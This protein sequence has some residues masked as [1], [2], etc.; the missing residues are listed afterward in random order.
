M[1]YIRKGEIDLQSLINHVEKE[2]IE[3][4]RLFNES[5]LPEKVDNEF[6][7]KLLVSIRKNSY[8]L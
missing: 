5:N 7:N 8:N 4:D 1:I 2:I 6:V 3:V